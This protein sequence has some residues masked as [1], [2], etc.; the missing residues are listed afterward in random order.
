ML[1]FLTEINGTDL[2]KLI[3]N[4]FHVFHDFQSLSEPCSLI[5]NVIYHKLS[6]FAES[7]AVVEQ[8]AHVA[9]VETEER[10]VGVRRL[11]LCTAH[12]YMVRK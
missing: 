9:Q 1:N 2:L 6:V 3:S 12:R 10:V 8:G 11:T 4:I 5:K 7:E